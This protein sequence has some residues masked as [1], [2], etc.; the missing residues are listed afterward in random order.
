MGMNSVTK[1]AP[2]NY[3]E[4]RTRFVD[5]MLGAQLRECKAKVCCNR[6]EIMVGIHS[7]ESFSFL[8]ENLVP[9]NYKHLGFQFFAENTSPWDCI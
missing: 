9:R 2:E 7:W 1:L 8:A 6:N 4:N 5:E 3:A